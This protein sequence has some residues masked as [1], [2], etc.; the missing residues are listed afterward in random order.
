MNDAL[1]TTLN[2]VGYLCFVIAAM[3]VFVR[4]WEKSNEMERLRVENASLHAVLN[5]IAKA[6]SKRV[7][8]G[9]VATPPVDDSI[10]A[11]LSKGS[12]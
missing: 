2:V 8:G 9:P 11:T 4:S 3:L 6:V 5:D 1:A 7:H 10:P 12:E